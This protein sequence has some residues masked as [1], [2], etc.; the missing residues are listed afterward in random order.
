VPATSSLGGPSQPIAVSLGVLQIP[1][2]QQLQYCL[3]YYGGGHFKTRDGAACTAN[4]TYRTMLYVVAILPYWFRFAQVTSPAKDGRQNPRP[5]L[6][7]DNFATI[8]SQWSKNGVSRHARRALAALLLDGHLL[9]AVTS[10]RACDS[11]PSRRLDRC[12][13]SARGRAAVL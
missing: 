4:G 11:Q 13:E 10:S 5:S 3:C 1:F 2:L 9:S 7:S 12:F 6:A 8:A